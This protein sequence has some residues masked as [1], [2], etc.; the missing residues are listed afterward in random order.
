MKANLTL[1]QLYHWKFDR[2]NG[3]LLCPYDVS[4]N[5]LKTHGKW[6]ETDIGKPSFSHFHYREC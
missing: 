6:L 2:F 5:P 1:E 3:L 4:D